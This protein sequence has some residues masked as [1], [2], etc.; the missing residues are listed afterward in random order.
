MSGYDERLADAR[1]DAELDGPE[2]LHDGYRRLER[3]RVTLPASGPRGEIEQDREVLRAG[4]C[5]GALLVDPRRDSL[6]LI[7]Q[8][9]APA[10]LATGRG[11]LVEIVAGRVEPGEDLEVAARR[12]TME[13]TGLEAGRA[14]R[15]FDFM[16]SPGI[17]DET[18]TL[19]LVEVDSSKALEHAG[20]ADEREATRP[21][22]V[23]IDAAIASL[24]DPRP[25]TAY[26]LLALQWLA[27]N[28]H[29]MEALL[30]G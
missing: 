6:V 5:I 27:L 19:F 14:V 4:P 21:F 10:A 7:R 22:V 2:L 23:T 18:A 13:E 8:F 15:L 24:A 20:A 25:R 9:R 3:W 28:R 12:E 29:R 1:S 17:A 26:L 30:R 11:D 16:P